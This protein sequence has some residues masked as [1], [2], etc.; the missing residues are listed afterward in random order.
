MDFTRVMIDLGNSTDMTAND[1]ATSIARFANIMG[2]S[3][4][5]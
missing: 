3:A 2:M 5:G 4:D 1:A